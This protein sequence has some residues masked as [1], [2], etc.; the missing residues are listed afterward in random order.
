VGRAYTHRA[1]GRSSH[2]HQPGLPLWRIRLVTH[3]GEDFLDRAIDDDAL[4]LLDHLENSSF[5]LS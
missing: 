1:L 4:F 5:M 3:V 2:F